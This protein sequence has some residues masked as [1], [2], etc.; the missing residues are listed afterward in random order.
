MRCPAHTVATSDFPRSFVIGF[1]PSPS[2]CGPKAHAACG[3][4]RDLPGSG[5]VPY[6]VM[7]SSTTARASAPRITGP[8]MLPSTL[9]TASASA[10][11]CLS[12]LNSHPTA[13]LCTLRCR[14]RRRHRN[15]HYRAPATAYPD[16]TSTGWTAPA[17]LAHKQS[18]VPPWKDSGL[19]RC[20]HNDGARCI[21]AILP[22]AFHTED[23]PSHPRGA[24][25]PTYAV[26]FAPP[27][28]RAQGRPGAGLAP[29][30]RCAHVA[31]KDCTAAYR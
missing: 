12:R 7:G 3:R 27:R 17:C 15:T 31:Q 29:T 30:V 21:V 11:F 14:R 24:F 10:S 28:K 1:G 19:L 13:S 9:L 26:S 18:R 5:A 25:R 2:R 4:T 23:T 6:C 22:L 20:A 8:H 16:R